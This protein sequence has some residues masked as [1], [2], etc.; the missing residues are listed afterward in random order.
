MRGRV[1]IC[2]EKA[3]HDDAI[4]GAFRRTG[5]EVQSCEDWDHW[6]DVAS[7]LDPDLLVIELADP[8]GKEELGLPVGGGNGN[9]H[10][11]TPDG[12]F[13]LPEM[14]VD[15]AELEKSMLQQA[16]ERT[17][18]NQSAAARLLSISRYAL[19]YRVEKYSL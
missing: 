11:P 19:R 3:Y 10:D 2:G 18:G 16:L 8:G 17:A 9:G 1:L 7:E 15:L 6:R 14:G 12:G 5:Y 13:R 4:V